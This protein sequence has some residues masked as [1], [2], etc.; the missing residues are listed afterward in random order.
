MAAWSEVM[1]VAAIDC[2]AEANMPTCREYEVM[3][4]PSIK[5]FPPGTAKGE[6]KIVLSKRYSVPC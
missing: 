1:G 2:A 3:G 6:V 5:F 4:Y